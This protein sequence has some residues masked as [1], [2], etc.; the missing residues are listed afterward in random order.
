MTHCDVFCMLV[1]NFKLMLAKRLSYYIWY[2]QR[3]ALYKLKMWFDM[4]IDRWRA[5]AILCV[6][7][8]CAWI[9]S[10][11]DCFET[12]TQNKFWLLFTSI[13]DKYFAVIHYKSLH[14]NSCFIFIVIMNMGHNKIKFVDVGLHALFVIGYLK[15]VM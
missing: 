15:L 11:Y 4:E 10:S 9:L 2:E 7:V 12:S 8:S 1:A 6:C 13:E 3:D 5:W 14:F